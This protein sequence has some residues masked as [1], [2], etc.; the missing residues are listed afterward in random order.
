MTIVKKRMGAPAEVLQIGQDALAL[1][2]KKRDHAKRKGGKV[3]E[4]WNKAQEE[5]KRVV[6]SPT[7]AIRDFCTQCVGSRF[8]VNDCR[9]FTCPLYKYRPYQKG[10]E[11]EA[12]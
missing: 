5:K 7:R 12:V 3:L 4:A 2:R 8:A 10:S 9:G 6:N 11:D 1:W